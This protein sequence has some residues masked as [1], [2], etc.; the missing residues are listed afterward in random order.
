MPRVPKA[1]TTSN[2]LGRHLR[3][4]QATTNAESVVKGYKNISSNNRRIGTCRLKEVLSHRVHLIRDPQAQQFLSL[5]LPIRGP[6][7]VPMC[8][9]M[10]SV[11]PRYVMRS[12]PDSAC[13]GRMDGLNRHGTAELV[14]R[15][16]NSQTRKVAKQKY[17]LLLAN[18]EQD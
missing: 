9:R 1:Q 17:F 4:F 12:V 7:V 16:S 6:T 15:K 5:F 2:F 14:S 13:V 18:H 10:L 3:A 8:R 11:D